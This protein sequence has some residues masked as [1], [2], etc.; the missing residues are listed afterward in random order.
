[1]KK[2]IINGKEYN[3]L[4][5][6]PA[7]FQNI[8]HDQNKDGV[9]D[10][11]EQAIENAKKSGKSIPDNSQLGMIVNSKEFNMQDFNSLLNGF[12]GFGKFAKWILSNIFTL[13][14]IKNFEGQYSQKTLDSLKSKSFNTKNFSSTQTQKKE[15]HEITQIESNRPN[16]ITIDQPDYNKLPGVKEG[17]KLRSLILVLAILGGIGW[18]VYVMFAN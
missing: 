12:G 1:M 3:S 6:I 18:F 9:P 11:A 8:F 4:S 16:P 17:N 14:G 15:S 5:E 10:F 7:E 2:I 13:S